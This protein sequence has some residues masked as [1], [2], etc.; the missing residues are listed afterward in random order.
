MILHLGIAGLFVAPTFQYT[1]FGTN[2][3][4]NA[5]AGAPPYAPYL[6]NSSAILCG[7][8]RNGIPGWW[9]QPKQVHIK[10]SFT[11]IGLP[12][13]MSHDFTNR[14]SFCQTAPLKETT[15]LKTASV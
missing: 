1:M 4:A 3:L 13:S 2:S 15:W 8:I 5:Y 10:L 7:N 12:G 11:E 9:F 14:I 6:S